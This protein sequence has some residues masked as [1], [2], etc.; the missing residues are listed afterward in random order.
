MLVTERARTR[1]ATKEPSERLS[2]C[3]TKGFEADE[4]MEIRTSNCRTRQLKY[5]QRILHKSSGKKIHPQRNPKPSNEPTVSL[6]LTL[7]GKN[8]RPCSKLDELLSK[9]LVSPLISPLIIPCIT[10][11]KEF[12]LKLR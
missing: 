7:Q 3:Y 12:R 1:I 9:L 6:I 8:P 10:A 4:K 5:N 11:F 2:A